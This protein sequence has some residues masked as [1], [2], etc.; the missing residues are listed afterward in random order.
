MKKIILEEV[1]VYAHIGVSQKEKRKRQ[2]ILVSVEMEPL[3][4]SPSINDTI[5]NT[6]NYSLIR[7]DI[8]MLVKEYRCNLIETVAERVS[9]HI[10]K[11]YAVK[12][13]T[14]TVKKFPYR[15]VKHVAYRLT[16]E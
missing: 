14:V 1:K 6:I 11:H 5:N 8:Q 12:N 4:T 9:H 3:S 16:L 10:K 13:L 7:K 2:K 15:G